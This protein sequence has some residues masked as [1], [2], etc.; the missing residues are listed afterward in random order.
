MPP[1]VRCFVAPNPGPLTG[2][3]TNSYVVGRGGCAVIDPGPALSGHLRQ[4]QQAAGEVAAV[5]VTHGHPDHAAGA[6]LLEAPR[7][8]V[9]D[10]LPLTFPWGTL[11]ALWTPGHSRDHH[12]FYLEEEAALFSGDL[13]PGEG[14]VIVE[15]LAAYMDSLERVLRLELRVLFPGHGP[16]VPD[17]H[18][19]IREILEHRREREA[20]IL[21]LL[22]EGP[23][24]VAEIRRQVYAG[25]AEGLEAFAE[26][27]VRAHLAK[28][29][30]EERAERRGS[31]WQLRSQYPGRQRCGHPG[32][33]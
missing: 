12:C 20:Q 31:R 26:Q 3:G 21:G 19:R 22:G 28:L 24:G 11:H 2:R 33:K 9:R 10:G 13:V 7:P 16:E 30:A 15:D 23:A 29:E 14:T 1:L 18:G 17:P 4:L 32:P 25:L 8:R 6:R 5:L 27:N